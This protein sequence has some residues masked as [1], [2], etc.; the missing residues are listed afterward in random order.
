MTAKIS[1]AASVKIVYLTFKTP[2]Q[3]LMT[4]LIYVWK[5]CHFS[6]PRSTIS[7][8]PF[9]EGGLRAVCLQEVEDKPGRPQRS[10]DGHISVYSIFT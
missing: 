5:E 3:I 4:G 9:L 7:C 8:S 6:S 1:S 10:S 2:D